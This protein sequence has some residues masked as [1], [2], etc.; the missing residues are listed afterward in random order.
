MKETAKTPNLN[1]KEKR[2][3][4][5]D[6]Q[7]EEAQKLARKSNLVKKG[8]LVLVVLLFGLGGFWLFKEA[9]K[10]SPNL[11]EAV[12]LLS[13]EHIN[14][15]DNHYAYNSNP[16]T[17]GPHYP[18]PANWGIYDNQ[19]PD[20]QLVHNLEHGGVWVSYKSDLDKDSLEKLKKLVGSYRSKVILEPRSQNDVPIAV[21][22]WG[23][24][25]KLN[26]YEEQKIKEFI[27]YYRNRGPEFIPD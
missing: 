16:P 1:K 12:P 15:G 18:N 25:M 19:L 20:E 24:L 17:S 14:P 10:P 3:Y 5:Q 13:R 9:A 6:L 26:S 8:I 2:K 22:S 23:R 11:G 27:D 4:Y 7:R 21:A